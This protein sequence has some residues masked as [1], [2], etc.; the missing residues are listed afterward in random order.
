MPFERFSKMPD[1]KRARLL[2]AAAQEFATHGFEAASLNHILEAAHIGKSSA[3][4]YFADKADLF[5]TVVEDC[6]AQL[7]LAPDPAAMGALTAATFWDEMAAMH[8]QP[9]LLARQ[10]PWLFG[11]LRA[12]ERLTAESLR[13]ESLARLT[14]RLDQ[15]LKTGMGLAITQGQELGLI[16]VDLPID[17]LIALFRAIDGAFDDW[18]LAH[19]D[20]LNPDAVAHCSRQ[21]IATVRQALAPP[22]AL[23]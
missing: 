8:D 12:A 1:D 4:Y 16:R 22:I 21:A 6:L 15:Y 2:T 3:Y 23:P 13:S 9:L 17:L 10:R 5:G 7:H 20:Q 19:W 18:L 11:T 14:T